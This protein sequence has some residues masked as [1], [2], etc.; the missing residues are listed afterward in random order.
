MGSPSHV[1]NAEVA[2]PTPQ[3]GTQ[4]AHATAETLRMVGCALRDVQA[5]LETSHLAESRGRHTKAALDGA[6]AGS[7][8]VSRG[9]SAIASAA[10]EAVAKALWAGVVGS[11]GETAMTTTA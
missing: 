10:A 1:Q 6:I 3:S 9:T 7:Q 4:R 8:D 2:H 5:A 11:E